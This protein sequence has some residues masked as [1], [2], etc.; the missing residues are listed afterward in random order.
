MASIGNY[1]QAINTVSDL[2]KTVTNYN[3]IKAGVNYV[4]N[5]AKPTWRGVADHVFGAN[6]NDL[7]RF[8]TKDADGNIT[9]AYNAA[10]IAGSIGGL[11][12]GYRFASGG[13]LYRDKDGNVDIAG[14]PFI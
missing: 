9:G 4:R 2:V 10:K 8:T 12:I 1:S 11:A 6:E 7:T 3:G 14:I 13:G 5:D